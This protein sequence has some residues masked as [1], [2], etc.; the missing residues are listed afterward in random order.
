MDYADYSVKDFIL[1]ESFQ[2]WVL[3]PDDAICTFWNSWLE[4]HPEKQSVVD[5]A[6]STIQ[7]IGFRK[8]HPTQQD[9]SE[10][11][12]NIVAAKTQGNPSVRRAKVVAFTSW[13]TGFWYKVAAV[14]LLFAVGSLAYLYWPTDDQYITCSTKYGET[15]SIMLPDSSEVYLNANST[16]K[17][18]EKWKPKTPREVW[19]DG[20]A[21]FDVKRKTKAAKEIQNADPDG[22]IVHTQQLD[23]IVLG[24]RFNVNE[25]RGNTKVILHSGKVKLHTDNT[26]DVLMEPGELAELNADHGDLVK[27]LVEDTNIYNAWI[28]NELI[29]SDTPLYEIATTLED[30]YGLKIEFEEGIAQEEFTGTLPADNVDIFFTMLSEYFDVNVTRKDNLVKVKY[31]K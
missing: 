20:E 14:L 17:Y 5:E 24:T 11:W 30:N 18:A 29:F 13:Q 22:F 28:N 8:E 23:V 3:Q 31:K 19:L 2:K 9:L 4:L 12:Q 10:V 26:P 15:R 27:K 6:R 7:S 25:R 16:I 1:D 21:F